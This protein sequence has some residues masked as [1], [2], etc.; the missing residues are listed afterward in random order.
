MWGRLPTP[1][2][3][4]SPLSPPL[5]PP[6]LLGLP[7][8]RWLLP[9]R[10]PELGRPPPRMASAQESLRSPRSFLTRLYPGHHLCSLDHI[11][12]QRKHPLLCSPWAPR[13]L[14][15]RPWWP[16]PS[17]PPLRP[18]RPTS[19]SRPGSRCLWDRN[20]EA[21]HWGREASA[22]PS[23]VA[24]PPNG[25]APSAS[26]MAGAQKVNAESNQHILGSVMAGTPPNITRGANSVESQSG[27]GLGVGRALKV[28][29]ASLL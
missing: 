6:S 12:L 1:P 2:L 8:P 17:L 7:L 27:V 26:F 21:P 4:V 16:D 23:G 13:F 10:N 3:S 11:A 15:A 28:T 22:S 24:P 5:P 20:T 18:L 19:P 29:T 25:R 9:W 14:R